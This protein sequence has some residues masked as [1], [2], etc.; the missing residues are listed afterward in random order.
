MT[1]RASRQELDARNAVAKSLHGLDRALVACSGGPDSI[2]LA[3]A[4]A[5]V[6]QHQ[7]IHVGAV[8]IDH[9][10]QQDSAEM[11]DRAAQACAA[12]ELNPVLVRVVEVNGRGG[13]EAAAR[14]A[15]YAA[16][17]IA[18]G[19]DAS[20]AVLLGHT[21]DDQAETVLLR[22]IRG[23]GARSLAAMRQTQGLWR[24]PFLGMSRSDIHAVAH[25]VANRHNFSIVRDSHNDDPVF[26]RVRVRELLKQWP[27]RESAIVGLA[28]S[29][30][31]LAD[32]ADYLDSLIAPLIDE[33]IED[34]CCDV[35]DLQNLP[36]ALRTRVLRQMIIDAGSPAGSLS[37]EH[38]MSVEALV[39][40][41]HGQGDI[42]LPGAVC[43]ARQYGRLRVQQQP[44]GDVGAT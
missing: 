40:D 13:M 15:R 4:A 41:W 9:Q 12:M 8:I 38:V 26:A 29:A 22:L 35:V 2:A 11:A 44:S 30:T 39:S 10:L 16:L 1:T 25:A 27:D 43:A 23:S 32:D 20:Q 31:L 28:R 36:R 34:G 19:E 14:S 6:A 5:W 33:L 37:Y 3:G 7:G 18:A 24:R 17:E 42:S 21:R